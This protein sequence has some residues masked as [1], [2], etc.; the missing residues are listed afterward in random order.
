[1][2]D[3]NGLNISRRRALAGIGAI[4]VASAGAGVGT[5]AYFSDEESFN[6]NSLTAGEL[7]LKVDWEEHYNFPQIYGF[8]DP[9]D[10][11]DV[12][13]SEP[14]SSDEYVAMP[15]PSDPMVW[16]HEDDLV[17][18]MSNTSIEAFPDTDNDGEQEVEGSNFSNGEFFD[19]CKDGADLPDDLER[20]STGI[21]RTDNGD[22]NN[23]DGG[24]NPLVSL[25]DVK[26]GDFGELT[27]SYHLCDNPGYVWIIGDHSYSEGEWPELANKIQTVWWYDDGDNVFTGNNCDEKLYLADHYQGQRD[28]T[29]Y[30]VTINNGNAVTS[31][32]TSISKDKFAGTHIGTSPDGGT[33]YMV[34][35]GEDEL[36]VYDY[37]SDSLTFEPI[38]VGD[39]SLGQITQAAVDT[40]GT[41]WIGS[42]SDYLF[43]IPDPE[44]PVVTNR[45]DVDI[46]ISGADNVFASNGQ[47]YLY[48]DAGN[49]LHAVDL[50][51]GNTMEVA[52][53]ETG[54]DLTG[55][56]IRDTG[57]GSLLGSVTGGTELIEFDLSGTE[58]DRYSLSGDLTDHGFGDMATGTLCE[59]QIRRSTLADDLNAL[60]GG[61][62]Q[63]D[64]LGLEECF[65][66]GFTRY[67]GF[68]WW[69]PTDVGN[70]VQGD[71]IEF[72]I[73]F[74][75]EQC[76]HND[77]PTGPSSPDT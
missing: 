43:E 32:L 73:G 57:S 35:E 26:P 31:E 33:V 53:L 30:E 72:D 56:T 8:D 55:L 48:T 45:L 70:E 4:G 28:P 1:M 49:M 65:M 15:D 6:G 42:T 59:R 71:S 75:T 52:E 23:G 66:P 9:T 38:D 50:L 29:L 5:S 51:S 64:D 2:S 36:A 3:N 63:L 58:L 77:S 19:P 74:Y 13:R 17:D 60:Q 46:N 69:L 11:L 7:D 10:G 21:G 34:A 16:V 24:N 68:A 40:D 67:I 14:E 62:L 25:D 18:Y 20:D 12:H 41:L 76:R 22:T 39:Y 54:E 27:L 37:D 47:F 61:G 44:N